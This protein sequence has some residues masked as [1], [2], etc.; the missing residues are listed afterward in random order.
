MATI[1]MTL[2]LPDGRGAEAEVTID[3]DRRV[4][5][6]TPEQL[7]QQAALQLYEAVTTAPHIH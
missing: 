1:K 2:T 6:Y 3:T 5:R 7:V 4:P